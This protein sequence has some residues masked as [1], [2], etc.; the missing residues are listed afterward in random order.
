MRKPIS[1]KNLVALQEHKVKESL[2]ARVIRERQETQEEMRNTLQWRAR[3]RTQDR[4]N[5]LQEERA[6]R[7]LVF[8]C[9]ARDKVMADERVKTARI[10]R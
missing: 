6:Q 7:G 4:E 1:K 2:I 3:Q 5:R 8:E 9:Y 10:I